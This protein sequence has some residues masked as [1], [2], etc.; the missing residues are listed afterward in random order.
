M[1]IG[2][3]LLSNDRRRIIAVDELRRGIESLGSDSYTKLTYYERWISS[4]TQ[5]LLE[6]GI[7]TAEELGRKMVEVEVKAKAGQC[8]TGESK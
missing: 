1:A 5:N 3:M 4:I 8:L 7:I 2:M 6:K